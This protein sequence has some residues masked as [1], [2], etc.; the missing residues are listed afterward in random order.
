LFNK[1]FV[2]VVGNLYYYYYYCYNLIEHTLLSSDG[3]Y[4]EE[5]EVSYSAEEE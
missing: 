4:K 1:A 3:G 2:V 5:G